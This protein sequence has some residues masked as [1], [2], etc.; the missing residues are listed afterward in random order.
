MQ[1]TFKILL[2]SFYGYLGFAQGHFADFDAAERVTAKGREI[3]KHM[4]DWLAARG[5]RVVEIDTDG[6]YFRPPDG[7]KVEDLQSGLAAELPA[8]IEVEFDKRYPAMFSYKAKNYALLDESGA[9]IIRG[10]ALK[11]RGMEPYLRD[12]LEA[13]LRLML[14]AEPEKAAALRE[15]LTLR[16][17]RRELS[18]E[19]LAKTEALQDSV[20]SYL[21]KITASSRNR[22]AAF[23]L[24]IKS[25]RNYQ[26]GDQISYYITGTSKKVTAYENARFVS[27]W[28]PEARDENVEYYVAKL[29]ELATKFQEH[30]SKR[31]VQTDLFAS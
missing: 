28:N 22:S 30:A 15:D 4:V 7:V 24:A 10:A 20:A 11:S 13:F 29:D 6:I 1:G 23:E 8:G 9:I 26:A 31:P 14:Q 12:Y 25:G 5:A 19:A 21:K 16:I 2:N 27:E 17:R 18:I 3:L